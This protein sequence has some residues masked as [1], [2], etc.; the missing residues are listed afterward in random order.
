MSY[1]CKDTRDFVNFLNPVF[2]EVTDQLDTL[3]KAISVNNVSYTDAWDKY[4][5]LLREKNDSRKNKKAFVD[6][7][8]A[9]E[10]KKDWVNFFFH[11]L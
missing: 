11:F 2:Q 9:L 5:G 1:S 6:M 7:V 8:V 4:E 10:A 3:I